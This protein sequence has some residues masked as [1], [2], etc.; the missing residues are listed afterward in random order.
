M[1]S[2][3]ERRRVYMKK[4]RDV[5]KVAN[6]IRGLLSFVS[7]KSKKA[8]D[9]NRL[10]DELIKTGMYRDI[11]N[12]YNEYLDDTN[13]GGDECKIFEYMKE[14]EFNILYLFDFCKPDELEHK[15]E[16]SYISEIPSIIYQQNAKWI[17]HF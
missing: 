2:L 10:I 3:T 16:G 9:Q 14:K 7:D 5:A 8:S 15:K 13:D 17:C 6:N 12:K 11:Y 4:A 1:T